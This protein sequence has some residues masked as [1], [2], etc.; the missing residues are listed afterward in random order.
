MPLFDVALVSREGGQPA[1]EVGAIA[2]DAE[3]AHEA[4]SFVLTKR[5]RDDGVGMLGHKKSRALFSL[6][7]LRQ[8]TGLT[9][10]SGCP[11]SLQDVPL[12]PLTVEAPTSVVVVVIVTPI[13]RPPLVVF[14]QEAS[15]AAEVSAPTT[16]ASFVVAPLSTVVVPLLSVDV[17][18]TTALVMLSPP[19]S[20]LPVPSSTV[21]ALVSTS[22]HL[23]VSLDH[24]YTSSDVDSLW[25]MG[26]KPE[27]KTLIGFVSALDKNL[28]Q[29]DGV[30]HATNSTKVF[31]L[32]SLKILEENGQQP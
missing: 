28:I 31:L 2:S 25:G 6:C 1:V 26:Y 22:F 5:K 3:V 15:F 4:S 21:L 16:S 27:Q 32:Q 9:P 12:A 24:I 18:T 23:H 8:A 29:S 14:V 19:F 10:S 11:S 7:A 13:P 17:A 20:A 30:K